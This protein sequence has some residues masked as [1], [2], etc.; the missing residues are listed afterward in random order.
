MTQ[1][2]LVTPA[3]RCSR[4]NAQG[5]QMVTRQSNRNGNAGRP[6]F[7]CSRCPAFISFGDKR[8][9]DQT[10]PQCHCQ[11]PSRR[12]LNGRDHETPRGLHFVCGGYGNCNYF[13]R[14]TTGEGQQLT[15]EEGLVELLARTLF[16]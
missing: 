2:T 3:P 1:T 5:R 14:G 16:I 7:K 13:T 4:C 11:I 9:I 12:Q 15:V 6:Y 10:N 8:G